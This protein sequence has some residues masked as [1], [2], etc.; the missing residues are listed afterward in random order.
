M[1]ALRSFASQSLPPSK[2]GDFV[3]SVVSQN[4]FFAVAISVSRHGGADEVSL[5]Q[6][7]PSEGRG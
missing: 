7:F 2:R 5:I 1:R 4:M 3:P 6:S